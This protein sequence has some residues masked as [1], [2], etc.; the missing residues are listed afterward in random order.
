MTRKTRRL[1]FYALIIIFI[2]VTPA[3]IL[4]ASGFAFDWQ[5]RQ[6]LKT[7][8]FYFASLPPDAKIL[9]DG[10]KISITPSYVSRLMPRRYDIVI[11]KDGYRDWRKNLDIFPQT[12]TE[13]R[14]IFL[15]PN[16]PKIAGVLDNATSAQAYFL[17]EDQKITEQIIR[18]NASSTI[19]EA[20]GWTISKNSLYYV[21]KSNNIFYKTNSLGQEKKQ[22]SIY[23]LP[24]VSGHYQI[25][26]SNERYAIFSDAGEL[27]L[28]NNQTKAF[29]FLANNVLGAGFS[30]D[31]EKLLYW[32]EHEIWVI[33]LA[34]VWSQPYRKA[35]EKDLITRLADNIGQAAW[36][37]PTNENIIYVVKDNSGQ[38]Q[39]KITELDD[40]DL[41]NTYGIY[42]GRISEIYFNPTDNL[43]YILDD[44]KL[45]SID[46]LT[47]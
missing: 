31:N 40:R 43:L 19:G 8:A 35:G 26:T 16:G 29:D 44:K 32:T 42:A 22:L 6:L 9:I 14:K 17:S 34:D 45:Y 30:P 20:A 46:L 36:F 15:M 11:A 1:I 10:Q 13:A 7:G 18:Q 28:F 24:D 38:S 3:T 21:Q 4:Y 23:P 39:I 47:K 41:R 2:L 37:S 5:S 27:Y 33:W 25:E 12:A